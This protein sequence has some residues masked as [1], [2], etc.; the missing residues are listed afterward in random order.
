M[1]IEHELTKYRKSFCDNNNPDSHD[2]LNIMP[3]TNNDLPAFA[4]QE[5]LS[6]V[7]KSTNE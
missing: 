5:A 2:L 4:T 3:K 6:S 7:I 1:G